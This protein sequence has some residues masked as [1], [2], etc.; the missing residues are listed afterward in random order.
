MGGSD[1][2]KHKYP[3][4][5]PEGGGT[6]SRRIIIRNKIVKNRLGLPSCL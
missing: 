4:I 2:M 3:C 5:A 1:T 6:I